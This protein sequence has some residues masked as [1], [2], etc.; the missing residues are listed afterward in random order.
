VI[1][2]DLD[3]DAADTVYQKRRADQVGRDLVHAAGKERPLERSAKFLA[4]RA[5]R[6]PIGW[7]AALVHSAGSEEG[8]KGR[9]MRRKCQY[10]KAIAVTRRPVA[11]PRQAD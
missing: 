9:I 5:R 10:A 11:I 8:G 3:D 7:D 4:D 1:G 6:I 2:L